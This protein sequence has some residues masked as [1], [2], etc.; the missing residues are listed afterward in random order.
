MSAKHQG[1]SFPLGAL[2]A[3]A[4]GL[5]LA[6]GAAAALAMLMVSRGLS[7]PVVWPFATAAVCGGSL[8]G[9]YL[10]ARSQKR[11]GLACG[12]TQ[13]ALF[14]ALLLAAEVLGGNVP[15]AL[16]IVRLLLVLLGGCV[17]GYLG[18]LR[19]EKARRKH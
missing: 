7:H 14:A 11:N 10:L 13:G 8:F 3:F 19:A 6:V 4:G 5:A 12:A 2:L 15:D 16:Q 1:L 18:M 9:G 17:G